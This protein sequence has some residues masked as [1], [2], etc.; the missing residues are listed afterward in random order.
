MRSQAA[1]GNN[2]NPASVIDIGDYKV[3]VF[4]GEWSMPPV[5]SFAAADHIPRHPSSVLQLACRFDLDAYQLATFGGDDVEGVRVVGDHLV[6]N[7]PPS[8]H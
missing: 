6:V 1:D 4:L 8:K 3:A 5:K 2:Q 7:S